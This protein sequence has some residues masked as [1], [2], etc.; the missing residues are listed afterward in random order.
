MICS[1]TL[2]LKGLI[3]ELEDKII[4]DYINKILNGDCLKILT[5]LPDNS[6]DLIVTDPPYQLDSIKKRWSDPG[7]TK[8]D[9]KGSPH[10]RVAR[11]FMGKEWDVLPP[12]EVWKECLRV[13]KPGAFAFIMCTPRQDS[14]IEAM[15]RVRD[16][17]FMMGFTPIFWSYATGLV[18]AHNIAKAVDRKFGEVPE[19]IPTEIMP[20]RTEVGQ[21][22]KNRRCKACGKPLVSGN[23]CRCDRTYKPQ[24]DEA[25]ALQGSYGGFQPKPA[26]EVILVAMKP[27]SEDTYVQQALENR[28]GITWMDDTRIPIGDEDDD[29]IMKTTTRSKRQSETW[30]KGSGFKNEENELAGLRPEG[31]F[32]A[33]LLV[34]DDVFE[35]HK[36][37]GTPPH[38]VT[39]NVDK[40]EGYGS[41]TRRNGEVVNYGDAGSFSRYFSLDAWW[42]NTCQFFV[43][44]KPSRWEKNFGLPDK[45]HKNPRPQGT[46]YNEAEPDGFKDAIREGNYH[47]TVKPIKLMSY[48]ITMGSREGD[49]VLDPYLGSGTTAI[50][51]LL[52]QR[53]FIGIEIDK[54]YCQVAARRI[55]YFLKNQKHERF[56]EI[57][58][59]VVG[60]VKLDEFI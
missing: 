48:I 29:K 38:P 21:I 20:K 32:P 2:P 23:P 54:N 10:H 16:A 41:I 59:E 49:V 19:E 45:G 43:V 1:K 31:R 40:Y 27:L 51:T 11:G 3:T 39:S 12:T 60:G 35:D 34:S 33:N 9:F 24:T 17:G 47:P 42:D 44:T 14:L 8:L 5:N 56:R 25:R 52:L 26:V 15:V 28:K 22:A 50:A 53:S 58:D 37:K 30:E 57:K 6:V 13:L 4:M 55:G 36:D 7:N 46:A 18:K